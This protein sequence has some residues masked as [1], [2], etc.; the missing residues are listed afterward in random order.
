MLEQKTGTKV[1]VTVT[2]QADG[3]ASYQVTEQSKEPH[4]DREAEGKSEYRKQVVRRETK[5]RR[6]KSDSKKNRSGS[7]IRPSIKPD[8]N[9]GEERKP[10]EE[11]S[12]EE[13]T[14]EDPSNPDAER[15]KLTK[16]GTNETSDMEAWLF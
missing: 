16:E 13:E 2:E 9:D 4:K 10:Q 7:C 11:Q 12:R 5:N 15:K 1:E 6:W 14:G 8:G 3:T